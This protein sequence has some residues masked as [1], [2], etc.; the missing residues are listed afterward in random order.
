VASILE[1]YTANP[2]ADDAKHNF[3][4]TLQKLQFSH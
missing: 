2:S 3:E 4:K 1:F